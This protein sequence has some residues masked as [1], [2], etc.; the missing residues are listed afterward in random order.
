ME[1]SSTNI[2]GF[3][4]IRSHQSAWSPIGG[5]PQFAAG[6]EA[7]K[8]QLGRKAWTGNSQL[9]Q[10]HHSQC[11]S[12]CHSVSL[13]WP[14]FF[15]LF[16]TIYMYLPDIHCWRAQINRKTCK[17]GRL[18]YRSAYEVAIFCWFAFLQHMHWQRKVRTL[19]NVWVFCYQQKVIHF[20]HLQKAFKSHF[21]FPGG[22]VSFVNGSGLSQMSNI[23]YNKDV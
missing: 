7:H 10:C 12:Q 1:Q 14:D 23:L 22:F 11:H 20:W 2:L 4:L 6:G 3:H 21:Q 5:L 15:V 17:I 13:G 9:C 19:L 8:S 18:W 16:V